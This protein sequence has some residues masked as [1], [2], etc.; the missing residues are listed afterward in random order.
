[1]INI[2]EQFKE[3]RMVNGKL[4]ED[5]ELKT[6][7]NNEEQITTGHINDKPVYIKKRF[8]KKKQNIRP[9]KRKHHKLPRIPN[10]TRKY[11][12]Y[13]KHKIPKNQRVK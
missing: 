13:K 1:M 3:Y 5:I 4:I 8:T 12:S 9:N 11:P 2:F 6:T 7:K 10:R